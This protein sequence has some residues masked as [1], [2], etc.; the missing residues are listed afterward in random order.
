MASDPGKNEKIVTIR[1]K[2]E[3]EFGGLYANKATTGNES[4]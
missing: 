1:W 4:S 3:P 2:C